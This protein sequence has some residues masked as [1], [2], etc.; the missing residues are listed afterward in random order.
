MKRGGEREKDKGG[1]KK[2]GEERGVREEGKEANFQPKQK[3]IIS[4][5]EL[6]QLVQ[7]YV[8]DLQRLAIT[9][10]FGDFLD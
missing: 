4:T 6:K 1:S 9:Y 5:K 10:E 8:A 7:D 3:D 2:E